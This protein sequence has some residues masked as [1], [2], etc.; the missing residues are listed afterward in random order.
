VH[1]S[2]PVAPSPSTSTRV[3]V[4]ALPTTKSLS[5]ARAPPCRGRESAPRARG[6]QQS[7]ATWR[8]VGGSWGSRP[9]TWR[10]EGKGGSRG[11]GRGEGGENVGG[12]GRGQRESGFRRQR[13]RE[14]C[15]I[16]RQRVCLDSPSKFFLYSLFPIYHPPPLPP[17]S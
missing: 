5:A 10:R 7:L 14:K 6:A 17:L 11:G 16:L 4:P 2:Q 9:S 1:V 8:R 15:R 13:R 3:T 12:R